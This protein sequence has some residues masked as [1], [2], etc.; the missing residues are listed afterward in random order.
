MVEN[1]P[2]TNVGNIEYISRQ[3]AI[4]ALH[5]KFRDGFNED[6]WWNSTHVLA[7]IEAIPPADVVPV[8]RCKDC[9]CWNNGN[10][11]IGCYWDIDGGQ[12]EEMD[13]CSRGERKE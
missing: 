12:P 13:F 1:L 2:D 10:V 5:T 8:V 4:D 6:K 11:I 7:A 3:A 9:K